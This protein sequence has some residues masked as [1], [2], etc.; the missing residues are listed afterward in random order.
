MCQDLSSKCMPSLGVVYVAEN[1]GKRGTLIECIYR[2]LCP[3]TKLKF[4]HRMYI[5]K[6]V[7]EVLCLRW[8]LDLCP[9]RH[10]WP[11]STSIV[12]SFCRFAVLRCWRGRRQSPLPL[13]NAH[14]TEIVDFLLHILGSAEAEMN[15]KDSSA[16]VGTFDGF[17]TSYAMM[18]VPWGSAHPARG[19]RRRVALHCTLVRGC[20]VV[21]VKKLRE[22]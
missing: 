16:L 21:V 2:L 17:D 8:S 15:L 13:V 5:R 10:T 19:L 4:A 22:I 6:N 1:Y 14:A 12:A 9:S 7:A 20:R 3:I 11:V 18:D